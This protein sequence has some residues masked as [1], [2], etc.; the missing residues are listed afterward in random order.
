MKSRKEMRIKRIAKGTPVKI[1]ASRNF[2]QKFSKEGISFKR[3]NYRGIPAILME[4]FVSGDTEQYGLSIVA[5]D[6][7]ETC[8]F[9]GHAN[10][11]SRESKITRKLVSKGYD[12]WMVTHVGTG[13]QP[14]CPY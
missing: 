3:I 9:Y 8:F 13:G 14:V 5:L 7:P 1:F 12:D 6:N 10:D 2:E 4:G 11:D